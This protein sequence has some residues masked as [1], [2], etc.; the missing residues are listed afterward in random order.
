MQCNFLLARTMMAAILINCTGHSEHVYQLLI[1]GKPI[2][3][4][5][6]SIWPTFPSSSPKGLRCPSTPS[7]LALKVERQQLSC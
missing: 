5:S 2:E 3:I 6:E 4:V 7:A 1:D